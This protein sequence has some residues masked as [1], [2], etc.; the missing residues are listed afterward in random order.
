MS[1]ISIPVVDLSGKSSGAVEGVP[2]LFQAKINEAV[3]HFV[4]EGQRFGFYKKTACT[5]TRSAVSGGGKKSRQQ[6]GSGGARQG[7]T[8]APHWPGGGIVF[9]P[10]AIVRDF[11]VNKKVREQGLCAVVSDRFAGG[12]IRILKSDVKKPETKAIHK[13][14]QALDLGSARVGIVVTDQESALIKGAQNLKN[15]DVL[16][17]NKWTCLD[18]IKTDSLIFSNDAFESL[19]KRFGG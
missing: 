16:T 17:E 14:L 6:K 19:N 10:S 9:G 1:K 18:F 15:V 3:V 4:C 5:K 7:G 8:R 11:K 2:A 13:V 12:Q